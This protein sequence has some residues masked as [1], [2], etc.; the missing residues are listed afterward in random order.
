MSPDCVF[1]CIFLIFSTLSWHVIVYDIRLN[2]F[3]ELILLEIHYNPEILVHLTV[4]LV[5]GTETFIPQTCNDTLLSNVCR[6]CPSYPR[7][8]PVLEAMSRL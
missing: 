2:L 8:P 1:S 6:R 5:H 3:P 7:G 4:N